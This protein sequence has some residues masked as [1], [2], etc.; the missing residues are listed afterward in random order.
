MKTSNSG[1]LVFLLL[2]LL[3][4]S[5]VFAQPERAALYRDSIRISKDRIKLMQYHAALGESVYLYDPDS[6][7]YF[8]E[9]GDSIA[10]CIPADRR[11]ANYYLWYAPLLNNTAFVVQK[12][13]DIVRA[14]HLY[15]QCIEAQQASGD[16]S[17]IGSSYLNLGN[18]YSEAGEADLALEYYGSAK[19]A[20]PSDDLIGLAHCQNGIGRVFFSQHKYE[21]ALNC[22]YSAMSLSDKASMPAGRARSLINIGQLYFEQKQLTPALDCFRQA[23]EILL[24]NNGKQGQADC[25]Y[26][27]G[28]IALRN[29]QIDSARYYGELSLALSKELGF[30]RNISNSSS[31]LFRVYEMNGNM[32]EALAMHILYFEM[33]DSVNN[34]EKNNAV[35]KEKLRAEYERKTTDLKAEQEKKTLLA[36]EAAK[37]QRTVNYYTFGALALISI[38]LIVALRSYR[39]KKK[40]H[41]IITSQ[42]ILVDEKNKS[43]TDSISYASHLQKALMPQTATVLEKL[44][45][46]FVFFQAKD[47]VSGDFFWTMTTKTHL[48]VAVCDSTG[49]GVPGAFVSLLNMSFIKE[50]VNEKHLAGPAEIFDFVRNR[51]VESFQDESS[52]DGMDGVLIRIDLADHS[53][54]IYAGANN[55][56]VIIRNNEI[57]QLPGD[58]MPVGKSLVTTKNFTEF[59]L[60]LLSGDLLITYTDGFPD[61]FGGPHGKK[62]KYKNLHQLLLV[63]SQSPCSLISD[64]L[65]HE[66]NSW[67]GDLEQTDDVLIC[68]IQF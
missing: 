68:G 11:D 60:H 36:T 9:Q 7:L 13:G 12:Q 32:K 14:V 44:K 1:L 55:A 23:L 46:A 10:Q 3:R 31:L 38:L 27:I 43:I 62:Y 2:F 28:E 56:P 57:I 18:L 45:D 17:T 48:Y 22:Y 20:L 64:K 19:R 54:S 49:H 61:Q 21:Q 50:A 16:S 47:I 33:S 42:K 37:H 39:A 34:V 35:I 53:K 6:A 52:Q 5:V 66:F 29:N 58:K 40:S 24:A 15:E 25:Y 51:L 41:E 8:F 26:Y 30:P 59:P 67:K 65:Q 63:N 4:S